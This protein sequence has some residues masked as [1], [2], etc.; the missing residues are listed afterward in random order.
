MTI[1]GSCQGGKGG[2]GGRGGKGGKGGVGGDPG[3]AGNGIHFNY[4]HFT[5]LLLG[6][7]GGKP[8]SKPAAYRGKC[9]T[10]CGAENNEL[11]LCP[12]CNATL[13]TSCGKGFSSRA[14]YCN[15]GKSWYR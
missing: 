13:C 15:C 5:N 6:G 10:A 7:P 4:L 3:P 14:N 8:K 12:W 2:D 11:L 9:P 1:A